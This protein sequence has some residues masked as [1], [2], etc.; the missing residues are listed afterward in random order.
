METTDLKA[1]QR[2]LTEAKKLGTV[3]DDAINNGKAAVDAAVLHSLATHLQAFQR[4]TDQRAAHQ[5]ACGLAHKLRQ[6]VNG[7]LNDSLEGR[8]Q[9]VPVEN[10]E[11]NEWRFKV[12]LRDGTVLSCSTPL[13]KFDGT[14]AVWY[15]VQIQAC[16]ESG[17]D[18][19]ERFD[20]QKDAC[21]FVVQQVRAQSNS[22]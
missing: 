1:L 15:E 13:R 12:R 14:S 10:V 17:C 18:E 4:N 7:V 3:V 21:D 2:A 8:K 5:D 22:K 9:L 11:A 19:P 6:A 16:D 20:N